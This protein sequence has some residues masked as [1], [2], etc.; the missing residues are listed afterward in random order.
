M[1]L[2]L[3]EA[4]K[5]SMNALESGVIE[6]FARE[7]DILANLPFQN[8]SGN[9]LRY[10]REE[11]LP[12]IGFRGINE[13]YTESTGILNPVTEPLVIAGGDLDVDQFILKTMGE[14]QRQGQEAMK[15]KALSL[16]WTAAFIRGDSTTNPRQ[17]DGLQARVTG[18]QLQAMGAAGAGA[19]LSL[20]SLDALIDSVDRPTHLI[21]NKAMRRRISQA[22][23]TPA[24]G[25]NLSWDMDQF[26]RQV[27]RYNDLP[28]LIADYDNTGAQI[29]GF[30]EPTPNGTPAQTTSVYCVSFA[31]GMIT[32]IQ[33]GQIE[34]RDLGELDTQPVMRT[35]VEWYSGIAIYHGRA[36]ARLRNITNAP[37][38]A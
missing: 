35:R 32:G 33:N 14:E 21:M 31:P 37:V 18:N 1:A 22:A 3:L 38:V 8:I 9:A 26:G 5:R 23:R 4:S 24:I 10:N 12:G 7:S 11:T 13:A 20:F 17:F 30:N 28:I 16:A 19:A 29:L 25:G 36:A 6:M 34:V 15:V 2:T 27:A